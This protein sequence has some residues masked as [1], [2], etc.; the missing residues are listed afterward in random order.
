MTYLF[1][2]RRFKNLN[3]STAGIKKCIQRVLLGRI[4]L[5][6]NFIIIIAVHVPPMMDTSVRCIRNPSRPAS[7]KYSHFVFT[8]YLPT[9]TYKGSCSASLVILLLQCSVADGRCYIGWAAKAPF[10]QLFAGVAHIT[11]SGRTFCCCAISSKLNAICWP[12]FRVAIQW[13]HRYYYWLVVNR[14][15]YNSLHVRNGE[16]PNWP[17]RRPVMDRGTCDDEDL[18]I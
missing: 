3:F 10:A 7:F 18:W 17:K 16:S 9:L 8:G 1:V 6:D 12:C 14:T 5:L 13:V 11:I 15:V 2:L 4:W